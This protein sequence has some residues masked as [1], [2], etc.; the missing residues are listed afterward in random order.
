MLFDFGLSPH[1]AAL[2]AETLDVDL[3][4]VEALALS[5]GHQD[6]AAGL[7]QL[8]ERVGKGGLELVLHPAAFRA[9]RY[10]KLPSKLKIHLLP[11]TREGVEAAAVKAAETKEPYPLLGGDLLFL[12]EIPRR[13]AFEKGMPNA[14][15][16]VDGEETWDPIEDDTGIVAHVRG[17]GLVVLSGCAHSGIVNTVDYGRE[18]TGVGQVLAVMGGFHL[19][20]PLFAGTIGPTAEALRD[21]DPTYVVPTHCTGRHAIL[22]MEREMP[23]KFLL[24]MVGTTLTLSA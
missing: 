5:H 20:G 18:L 15:Y 2:N 9:P 22:H 11:L 21:M 24:N 6:H 17:R 4:S 10:I 19:T 16:E 12:G 23:G 3:T 7:N 8:A 1:G 14:F 13:T